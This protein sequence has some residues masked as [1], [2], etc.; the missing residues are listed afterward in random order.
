M[1]ERRWFGSFSTVE[2]C[3]GDATGDEEE[4]GREGGKK[5]K[6]LCR[7]V[8]SFSPGGGGREKEEIVLSVY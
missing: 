6:S 7:F 5:K 8:K 1:N 3:D 2:R 4:R